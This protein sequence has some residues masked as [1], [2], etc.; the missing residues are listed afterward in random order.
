MAFPEVESEANSAHQGRKQPVCY[1]P[2]LAI[3]LFSKPDNVCQ[4]K[5]STPISIGYT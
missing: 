5:A 2:L 3:C 4:G 1:V